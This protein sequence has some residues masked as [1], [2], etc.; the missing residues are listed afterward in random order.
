MNLEGEVRLQTCQDLAFFYTLLRYMRMCL[1]SLKD[2]PEAV[3]SHK[4]K[5]K[6][7]LFMLKCLEFL[8]WVIKHLAFRASG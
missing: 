6:N 5:V 4:S 8:S 2:K 3:L 1:E 7:G